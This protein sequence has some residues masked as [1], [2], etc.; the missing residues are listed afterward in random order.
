VNKQ[1]IIR[2]IIAQL[3]SE[4]ELLAKAARAAHSEA[5]HESS[6]AENKYDTR[7]LEASYLAR[8]QS[9]QA[10]E[11]AQ[12]IADFEKLP[13]RNF[14]AADEIDIGALVIA[15]SR[16]E[17]TAYFIGPRGGGTEVKHAGQEVL[18]ITPRSPLGQQLVG[19]KQGDKIQMEIAGARTELRISSVS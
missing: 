6:K 2:E 15:E 17:R 13:L 3:A 9:K 18:V 16:K 7:G 19:R 11:A 1:E 14:T 4:L 10:A 5:T 12:A 8:G